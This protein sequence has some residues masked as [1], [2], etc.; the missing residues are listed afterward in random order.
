MSTALLLGIDIGTTA[1]KVI[2]ID[3]DGHILAEMQRPATLYSPNASWAEEEPLEWWQNV[4]AAIPECLQQAGVQAKRITG[5][6][7]SGMVP[8]TILVG[9]QGQPIRRSI[10]QND[11]R[12][13]VEIEYFKSQLEEADV[14]T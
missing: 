7:V 5:I 10:Q 9:P 2:L 14:Q 12:S 6:G 8:T 1:T 3:I 4:C 11:A 13:H